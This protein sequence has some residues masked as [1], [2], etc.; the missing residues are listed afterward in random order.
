MAPLDIML[1]TR[2]KHFIKILNKYLSSY[3]LGSITTGGL[4][5]IIKVEVVFWSPDPA[6]GGGV[7][8]NQCMDE[9]DIDLWSYLWCSVTSLTTRRLR[10][11]NLLLSYSQSSVSQT[12]REIAFHH[13]WLEMNASSIHALIYR[14]LSLLDLVTNKLREEFCLNFYEASN[15]DDNECDDKQMITYSSSQLRTLRAD[16]ALVTILSTPEKVLNVTNCNCV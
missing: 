8:I 1:K 11:Q 2:H 3:W 13:K 9:L 14:L 5:N 15:C 12:V 7:I 10:A 4:E 6:G 16:L